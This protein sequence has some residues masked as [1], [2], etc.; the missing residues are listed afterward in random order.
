MPAFYPP[1]HILHEVGP[2]LIPAP[3]RPRFMEVSPDGVIKCMKN[4][5]NCNNRMQIPVGTMAL[6]LKCPYTPINNKTLLPVQYQAPSYYCCQL[7]GEMTATSTEVLVFGSWSPESMAISFVD[8]C[9][10]TWKPL[11][12]LARELY[13]D[14]NLTKPTTLHGQSTTL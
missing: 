4:C 14:G 2:L 3:G 6:E 1:C 12:G 11:W 10:S 8:N 7:L 9:K 5:T 13:A